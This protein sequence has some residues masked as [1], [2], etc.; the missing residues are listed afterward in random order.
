MSIIKSNGFLLDNI[1]ALN[2]KFI[3]A[4]G[5][6][7][8]TGVMD[9][10]SQK[11]H[12]H[13]KLSGL[14]SVNKEVKRYLSVYN[15]LFTQ[16]K[17]NG[18]ILH[19]EQLEPTSH[20]QKLDLDSGLFSRTTIYTVNNVDIKIYSERFLDQKH[21]SFLYSKYIIFTSKPIN[22]EITHGYDMEISEENN[23]YFENIEVENVDDN[24]YLKADVLG[25]SLNMIYSFEKNFRHK[26]R[27]K[28][29]LHQET[30]S[31]R[32]EANRD[33]E[34]IKYVAIGIEDRKSREILERSLEKRKKVGYLGRLEKN[35][36]YWEK[37]SRNKANIYGNDLVSR[38]MDFNQFQLI[39]HR[40]LKDQF[41]ISRYGFTDMPIE[42][43][44]A[45]EMYMFRFFLNT[46]YKAARRFI[47][48]RIHQLTEAKERA[49]SENKTGALYTDNLYVNALIVVNFVDYIERTMDKSVLNVGGLEMILEISKFYMSYIKL[50]DKKTNYQVLNVTSLDKSIEG[51]DNSALLNY[52]IRDCFGKTANMVALAKVDKRKEIEAYL[53]EKNYDILINQ[54]REAR[55]K[56]YLQMPNVN[57]LIQ[58][59]D[60]Y[61]KTED[62]IQFP[63]LL[64]L[65]FLYPLDFTEKCKEETYNYYKKFTKPNGMGQFVLS[66]AGTLKNDEKDANKLFRSFLSLNL[67][68]NANKANNRQPYIDLGLSAGSYLY[69]VY[70]LASLKHDKYLLMADSLIPSDIR[71][72]EIKLKIAKNIAI[73]KIR[74]NSAVIEWNEEELLE[75][76]KG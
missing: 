71:R 51:I 30:Y 48:A 63:D 22:L 69:V 25:K 52:L 2:N 33:Y 9:E 41:N 58:Y 27:E 10:F 73:V 70:G 53:K 75:D 59:Y 21:N 26:N 13:L 15:P 32:T 44:F 34:I 57:S 62:I 7:G 39:S 67:Y 60:K 61:F 31:L 38:Y 4:N 76:E 12:A 43:S 11:D 6:I 45:T 17:A 50:N 40:P 65:F 5:Y 28:K 23:Q 14:V 16:V 3:L 37:L 36:G 72:L 66:L 42:D 46:D 56:I 68:D 54:I 35:V 74:R 29:I 24:I 18:T 1:E 64:N 47:I 20:E 55:R 19:P 49:I 8:I